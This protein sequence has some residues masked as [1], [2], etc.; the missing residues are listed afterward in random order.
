MQL[1][2]TFKLRKQ[3]LMAD[4][5]DPKG[6]NDVYVEDRAANAYVELDA[7]RHAQLRA[8]TLKL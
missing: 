2:G 5:F 6:A 7:G 4:G 8:G 1:T 3:T